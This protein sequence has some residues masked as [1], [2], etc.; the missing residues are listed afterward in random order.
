VVRFPPTESLFCIRIFK[1]LGREP[2]DSPRCGAIVVG[3]SGAA[4]RAPRAIPHGGNSA[5]GVTLRARDARSGARVGSA[6][7]IFIRNSPFFVRGSS[8]E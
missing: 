3:T 2:F 6:A 8:R 1:G 4:A 5:S 7:T